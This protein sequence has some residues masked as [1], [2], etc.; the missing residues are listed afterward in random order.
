MAYTTPLTA[1]ANATLTAAQW[2]ASVRDN[3]LETG[4]A[5][6]TSTGRLI[7]TSGANQVSERTP[8]VARV[9]GGAQ[10]TTSTT[11]V[12]LSTVG[13]SVTSVTGTS[14]I[15]AVTAF[16]KNTSA[17]LGGYVGIDVSGAS[18]IAADVNRSLRVMSGIASL[19]TRVSYVGGFFTVLT[20]GSNTFRCK[21]AAVSGGS[22]EFDERELV[23]IP[24]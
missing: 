22:A 4:P 15:F 21:Y 9:T 23:V 17:G 13:P 1:V 6:A 11:F 3:F 2:N 19:N 10:A 14:A 12:D 16:V 7:V 8:A 24:L 20:P 5:K 18:T